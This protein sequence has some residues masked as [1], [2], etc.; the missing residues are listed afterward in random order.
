MVGGTFIIFGFLI[1][2]GGY[3]KPVWLSR[4]LGQK[5]PQRRQRSGSCHWASWTREIW[6]DLIVRLGNGAARFFSANGVLRNSMPITNGLGTSF[7]SPLL[8]G[9]FGVITGFRPRSSSLSAGGCQNRHDRNMESGD[10]PTV[11]IA[12]LCGRR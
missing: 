9:A 2:L 3:T 8:V 6:L 4:F 12:F 1:G 7:D 10:N 11:Q 5:N